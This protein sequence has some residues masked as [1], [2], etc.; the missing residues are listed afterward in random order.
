MRYF[1]IAD[2]FCVEIES[3]ESSA[4]LSYLL[5]E[6][7]HHEC[8]RLTLP[9]AGRIT[10]REVCLPPNACELRKN[11]LFETSNEL[12][13]RSGYA[14]MRLQCDPGSF[15]LDVGEGSSPEM[16]YFTIEMLCRMYSPDYGAAFIHAS[17]FILNSRT[18]VVSA[19][20]GAGKTEVMIYHLLKGASFVADD[21]A[22]VDEKGRVFPYTKRVNLC[23]YPYNA[24]MLKRTHRSPVL[25]RTMQYCRK[26]SNFITTRLE[27]RLESQYFGLKLDYTDL[28]MTKTPLKW[29]VPDCFVW[30]QSSDNTGKTA[31]TAMDY[32]EKMGLCLDIESRRYFD[33]DGYLRLKY[34]F[35]NKKKEV[36]N[37]ILKNVATATTLRGVCVKGRDFDA[38]AEY[39]IHLK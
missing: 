11:V 2:L 27:S 32:A 37:Q 16:T 33:Y 15:S 14:W 7:H 6:W 28:A 23:E 4:I 9:V 35:L 17:A 38:V 22:I 5:G 13:I 25:W 12:Y 21:F 34:P 26:H 39:I 18:Y 3:Q 1:S 29:Y 8:K 10:V 31:V 24:A 36:R 30:L 20:G 19:F